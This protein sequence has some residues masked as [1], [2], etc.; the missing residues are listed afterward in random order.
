MDIFTLARQ[1]NYLGVDFLLKAGAGPN[2]KDGFGRTA[3]H[4][5]AT[6]GCEAVANVLL[7]NGADHSIQDYE[8]GWTALHRS[9]YFKHLNLT[10]LLI[11]YGAK[12]GD[13]CR[14]LNCN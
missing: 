5:C 14:S 8:S 9:L 13:R 7:S 6:Y 12:L 11:K 1:D 2:D 10:L 4:I 3:L